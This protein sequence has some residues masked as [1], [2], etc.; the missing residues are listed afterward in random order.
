MK[1]IWI[2]II[3]VI[4]IAACR[5]EKS[6]SVYFLSPEE[7]KNVAVGTPLNIKLDLIPGSF[8]SVTYLIDTTE[9]ASKTDTSSVSFSTDKM[10]LGITILTAKIYKDGIAKEI[11][12]N[13]VL[14]PAT[15]PREYSYSVINTFPHDTSSYTQ[16]LEYHDGIFY[17]SDGLT[18]ESSMRKVAVDGNVLKQLDMPAE[19]F[20]EG[21]TVVDDKVIQLTYQ[22]KYGIVYDKATFNKIKEFPYQESREGWGLCFDGKNIIKSDGTNR[23]YFL[24][25]DTYIE[26][27]YIEVYDSEGAVDSINELEY[28]DG[29]IYANI[30]QTDNIVI[31]DPATGAVEAELDLSSL[32]PDNDRNENADV[33][34]GIAWDAAGKRLF[35]T[36]KKWD[37]LFEIKI[38][39]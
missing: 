8:D 39:E 10:D 37:K 32:Y 5:K 14:L 16:G 7:G 17:E 26:Q 20:A 1:K 35:V 38:K 19:I 23:L 9:I 11:T 36:G 30:Y 28:I 18:G 3:T 21:L 25:K 12:T 24:N 6:S 27:G 33:L 34:N 22:N 31:I 2:C 29:K 4:A 13:L 15:A